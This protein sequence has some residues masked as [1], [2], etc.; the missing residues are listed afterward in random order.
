LAAGS[1]FFGVK[2]PTPSDKWFSRIKTLV[3]IFHQIIK[4]LNL[5]NLKK[6]IKEAGSD[7]RYKSFTTEMQLKIMIYAHI[8]GTASL[9]ELE[10]GFELF[11]GARLF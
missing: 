2:N 3:S 11:R 1:I 8:A 5:L 9:R 6:T 10:N 4:Y 7:K